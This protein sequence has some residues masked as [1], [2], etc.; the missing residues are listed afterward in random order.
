MWPTSALDR[1]S[2]LEIM[3]LNSGQLSS[4]WCKPTSF[5]E[6]H[7]KMRV[8]IYNISWR[9]AILSPS[10]ESL[11]MPYYFASSHLGRQSNGSTPI[12]TTSIHGRS[13]PMHSYQSFSPWAKPMLYVE[14][15][16][17][18]NRNMMNLSLRHENAFKITYQNVLIMGRRIGYS[19][20][21]FSTD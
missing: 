14:E 19:C 4:T 15:F 10:K 12:K 16:Q 2:T 7:I 1:Q 20:R 3:H 18:F 21:L 9:F 5:V 13:A 11:R 8:L 17:A 6:R